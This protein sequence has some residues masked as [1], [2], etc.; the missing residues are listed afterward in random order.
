[1]NSPLFRDLT[2]IFSV[3][4]SV[5][6]LGV[7]LYKNIEAGNAKGFAYEQAYQV[8]SVV[9][10]ANIP[11]DIKATI[12]QQALSV[13]GTPPAVFDLS[14]S[15]AD[16]GDARQV[17]SDVL[18]ASCATLAARLG[19]A[20]TACTQAKGAGLSCQEAAAL[21]EN[22]TASACVTCFVP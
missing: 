3:L 4:I 19:E 2:M 17:C 12:L 21:K 7:G 20:N 8:L 6:S 14:R 10:Q 15:S 1:M 9:Q 11:D 22:I 16:V 18:R 5:A 13:I